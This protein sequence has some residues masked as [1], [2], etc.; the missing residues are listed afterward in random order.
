MGCWNETC[1]LTHL[2][3]TV[4]DPACAFFILQRHGSENATD[5]D[6]RFVP[7]TLP[8]KGEYDDYGR[9]ERIDY[10]RAALATLAELQLFSPDHKDVIRPAVHTVPGWEQGDDWEGILIGLMDLAGQGDLYVRSA[11]SPD[12]YEKLRLVLVRTEFLDFAVDSMEG[13]LAPEGLSLAS[14]SRPGPTERLPSNVVR[15]I[16]ASLVSGQDLRPMRLLR[17]FMAMARIPWHPTT[18]SG[19]QSGIELDDHV[20]FLRKILRT[21]ESLRSGTGYE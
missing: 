4:G 17:A 21:A 8:F 1:M 20:A 18:G 2:P 7:V 6:G 11:Q 19:S 5:P 16:E 12:G 10:D 9:L 15:A 3:I 13:T 14:I